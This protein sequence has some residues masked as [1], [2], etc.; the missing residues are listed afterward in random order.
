MYIQRN[1]YICSNPM[2]M[3]CIVS[4]KLLQSLCMDAR[5]KIQRVLLLDLS[6]FYYSKIS[7]LF[8]HTYIHI[9]E[10]ELAINKCTNL[11]PMVVEDKN[12]ALKYKQTVKDFSA[13]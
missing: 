3:Q 11:V 13:I 8:I 2:H 4:K 10:V 7:V 5:T 9:Q 1:L 6:I 12:S